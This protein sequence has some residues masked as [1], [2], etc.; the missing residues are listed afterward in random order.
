MQ[1]LVIYDAAGTVFYQAAG[2]VQEPAG[3]LLFMWLE[4]PEGKVLKKIDTTKDE[5]APVYE[6]IPKS[7]V[8][9]LS[10]QVAALNIA[11]AEVLGV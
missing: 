5:H 7:Q 9:L 8:E 4:I 3:G 1:T 2:N 6:D 10:E 11:L